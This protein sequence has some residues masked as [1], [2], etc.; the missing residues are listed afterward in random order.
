MNGNGAGPP[1]EATPRGGTPEPV[2]TALSN[3][4]SGSP[5]DTAPDPPPGS[6]RQ[7]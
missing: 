6:P 2:P 1:V 5:D 7:A 3:R 4:G